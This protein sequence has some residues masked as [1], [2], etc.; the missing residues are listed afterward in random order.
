MKKLIGV[1]LFGAIILGECG[2]SG[3]GASLGRL[4]VIG[5]DSVG[6]G[7]SGEITIFKDKKMGCQYMHTDAA[8]GPMITPVLNQDGKPDCIQE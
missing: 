8:S 4:E 6:K 3:V 2:D 1:A 7:P 5:K